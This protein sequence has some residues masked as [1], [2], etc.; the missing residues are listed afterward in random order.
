MQ[1]S[2]KRHGAAV[3]GAVK[4]HKDAATAQHRAFKSGV[5]R[6]VKLRLNYATAPAPAAGTVLYDRLCMALYDTAT[7]ISAAL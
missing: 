1:H 4:P 6:R 7:H 5:I 2:T 3:H